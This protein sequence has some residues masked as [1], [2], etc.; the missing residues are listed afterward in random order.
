VV[1]LDVSSATN[2]VLDKAISL[3]KCSDAK[4]TGIY[5]IGIQPTLLSGV[6]NDKETK[7]AEKILRSMKKYCE[8][9]GIQFA[10]KISYGKPASAIA[11]FAEKG[12]VDLVV[13]GTKG[14][15]GFKGKVLGSVANSILH[16]TKVSV[17]LVR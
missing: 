4:I 15:G 5:V 17:F 6:I 7:K 16:E 9:K 13:I 1:A 11:K 12:K 8:K 10:F 2:K 3:A 14:I